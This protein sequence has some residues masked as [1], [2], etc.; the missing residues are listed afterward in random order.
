[1]LSFKYHDSLRQLQQVGYIADI[2]RFPR[3]DIARIIGEDASVV[4]E[5]LISGNISD[6]SKGTA[7]NV[8]EKCYLLKMLFSSVLKLARYDATRAQGILDDVEEFRQ[9]HVQPPWC[10]AQ[11]TIRAFIVEDGMSAV[12]SSVEWLGQY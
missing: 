5:A 10:C 8:H 7:D 3:L 4:L 6:N 11:K 12:Q 1:M 2:L 9:C